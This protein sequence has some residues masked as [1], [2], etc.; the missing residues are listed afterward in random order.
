MAT[1]PGYYS[2]SNAG[3][4]DLFT[5]ETDQLDKTVYTSVGAATPIQFPDAVI[6]AGSDISITGADIELA[7]D[8]DYLVTVTADL[9]NVVQGPGVSARIGLVNAA[10][11][12]VLGQ[13]VPFGQTFTTV[14]S[15][16]GDPI[17]VNAIAA[18]PNN[19]TGGTWAYPAQI[20]NATITVQVIGG[21][22][23]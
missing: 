13:P 10:D 6:S 7:A 9:N 3:A 15:V 2:A 11:D 12:S 8:L 18:A 16:V 23:V 5:V 20:V 4:Q 1:T 14:V 19:E 21:Y 17:T 22:T